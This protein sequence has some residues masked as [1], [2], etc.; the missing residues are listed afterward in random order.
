MLL[1]DGNFDA[2]RLAIAGYG[3]YHPVASNDTSEGRQANR[4]VDIVLVTSAVNG[5]VGASSGPLAPVIV[6]ETKR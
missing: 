3:E 1:S 2:Q 4:R 5:T 6:P